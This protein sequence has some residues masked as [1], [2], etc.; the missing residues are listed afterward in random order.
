MGHLKRVI[1]PTTIAVIGASE[2]P[3][4][5]G[6]IILKN[7]L[8]SGGK[9]IYPVNP[10]RKE[11]LGI[12]C[13]KNIIDAPEEIDLAIIANTGGIKKSVEES[14]RK[15]VCGVMII[16]PYEDQKEELREIVKG[17]RTR[18]IGPNTLGIIRPIS[19]YNAS[20]FKTMPNPGGVAFIT[21][22]LGMSRAFINW[23]IESHIGFSIFVS[24]GSMIDVDFGEM[25]DFLGQDMHTRSILIYMEE[26]IGNVKR[27]VSA[28]RGFA[29]NKPIIVLKPPKDEESYENPQTYTSQMLTK[30]RIYDAVF[31]RLGILRVKEA[32]DLFNLATVLHGRKLPK[33]PRLLVLTNT[34]G[35]GYM[36][37]SALKEE[38]GEP[39][40]ISDET[41]LRLKERIGPNLKKGV[42]LDLLRDAD[43]ER[44]L[45][46]IDECL[47]DKNVDGIL[48]IHAPQGKPEREV[49]AQGLSSALKDPI[50]PVIVCFF[51]GGS[52]E[53]RDRLLRSGIPAYDTPEEAVRTYLYMHSYERNLRSL[54]ETPRELSIDEIPPTTNLKLFIRKSLRDGKNVLTDDESQ[55]FLE[56]FNIPTLKV[57]LASSEEEAVVYANEIGFPCVMK[58]SSPDTIHRSDFGGVILGINSEDEV[59]T[60]F[61]KLI[62]RVRELH[63][64]AN[65]K[66][67]AIQKMLEKIDYEVIL[68]M[69]KDEEFGSIILFGTS[70]VGLRI[71]R[72]FALALPPLNQTL[73]KRLI[74]DTQALRI[75]N[76]Y[77]EKP[78]A[79]L[80]QLETIIVSFSNLITQ[81]PEILEMDINPIA[82]SDGKAYALDARI[83]LD[84]RLIDPKCENT[85]LVIT[86]Y[87]TR[88]VLQTVLRNGRR[89]ILRPIRPEDEPLEKEMLSSLSEETQRGRFFTVLKDITHDMLVK[90]C[91]IDYDREMAI[92][93]E[94]FEDGKR[95][96]IGI[97]RL[98][99]DPDGERGECA[100]VVH[101]DF[102]RQGLGL[103]LMDMLLAVGEEKRLK[104]VYAY[105]LSSNKKMLNLAK[106]MGFSIESLPDNLCLIK[107]ELT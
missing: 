35:A 49:L 50:K 66:G 89:V 83:V 70:G 3:D 12:P 98:I 14:V 57:Y 44:Y 2:R 74:E 75:L 18:I 21:Q 43:E 84:K 78:P 99:M 97:G 94:T 104:E 76:G 39:A 71:Y 47:K 13:I 56:A 73:A 10:K 95:R 55:K 36:A 100:V 59:R 106:K 27:F 5:P 6:F 32:R 107:V 90:F 48:L 88:Y 17:T 65:L 24:L 68:G 9:R 20:I 80:N 91:H 4:S 77:G 67:V 1:E 28:A 58:I 40:I 69:K 42:F 85:H 8:S 33:G 103:R 72:D 105:V 53:V 41:Y 93:A 31:K 86:P 87:P 64:R 92:V 11:I 96:I 38:G 29:R 15:G 34:R 51:G 61:D 54:Y 19:N 52:K 102:Q 37:L 7:L 25:I 23:G 45:F 79:D 26:T 22:T 62:R 82:I 63:P 16:S 46:V 30:D 60:S 101:D 81:F